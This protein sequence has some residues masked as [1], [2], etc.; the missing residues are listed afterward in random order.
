MHH[1]FVDLFKETSLSTSPNPAVHF[2]DKVHNVK[3]WLIPHLQNLHGHASPHCFKFVMVEQENGSQAATLFF[4]NWSD[5]A[6]CTDGEAIVLLKVLQIPVDLVVKC[7]C[8]RF[9]YTMLH[10]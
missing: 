3:E 6:W 2:M 5:D 9:S 4:K 7:K 10:Q 1:C 8:T